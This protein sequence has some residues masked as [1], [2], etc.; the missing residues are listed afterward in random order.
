MDPATENLP[1]ATE[2]QFVRKAP[3]PPSALERATV[4][5]LNR[6]YQASGQ[7]KKAVKTRASAARNALRRLDERLNGFHVEEPLFERARAARDQLSTLYSCILIT[8]AVVLGI[9]LFAAVTVFLLYAQ[10]LLVVQC[11]SIY[12]RTCNDRGTCYNGVC[13]CDPLFSGGLCTE[14]QIPGYDLSQ[15]TECN[16]NGFVLPFIDYPEVCLSS[17]TAQACVD[18]VQ[19][20][21][22]LLYPS[23]PVANPLSVPG[24]NTIPICTCFV[25]YGAKDCSGTTCPIDENGYICS[26]H[27]NTSVSLLINATNTGNGCQCNSVYTFY[28][29]NVANMF[30]P[31]QMNELIM[32]YN[33]F[34]NMRYCGRVYLASLTNATIAW[35]ARSDYMCHCADD[36]MGPTCGE[37]KCPQNEDNDAICYGNG[38]PLYGYGR[39][40]NYTSATKGGKDCALQCEEDGF[41]LCSL[42]KCTKSIEA[43]NK[44]PLFKDDIVCQQPSVCPRQQPIRCADGSCVSIPGRQTNQCLLGYAFGSTDLQ[45]VDAVLD[46]YR[47]PNITGPV[48]FTVCFGNTSEVPGVKGYL[49]RGG[50]IYDPQDPLVLYSASPL[51]YAEFVTNASYLAVVPQYRGA[52]PPMHSTNETGY[53]SMVFSYGGETVWG[54][55][56]SDPTIRLT[57]L[58]AVDGGDEPLYYLAPMPWNYS[59]SSD[60]NVSFSTVRLTPFLAGEQK[61]IFT[62]VGSDVALLTM[63]KEGF[64]SNGI[65]VNGFSFNASFTEY[66]LGHR[67]ASN[68]FLYPTNGAIVQKDACFQ[69]LPACSWYFDQVNDQLVNLARTLYI[70][71]QEEGAEMYPVVLAG[72]PCPVAF[73]VFST[74]LWGY[75]HGWHTRLIATHPDILAP[76]VFEYYEILAKYEDTNPD[77]F[78]VNFEFLSLPADVYVYVSAVALLTLRDGILWPCA[79][80]QSLTESNRSAL[81]A[82]YFDGGIVRNLNYLNSVIGKYAVGL[83]QTPV[84]A[85]FSYFRGQIAAYNAQN[86]TVTLVNEQTGETAHVFETAVRHIA[87]TDIVAGQDDCNLEI[88]SFRCPDGSCTRAES[89]AY[90]YNSTC[91]C[92]YA[93]PIANCSCIDESLAQWGCNCNMTGQICL[94]GQPVLKDYEDSLL[95]ELN[96]LLGASCSCIFF[97]PTTELELEP[98]IHAFPDAPEYE[99][100]YGYDQMVDYIRIDVASLL[101]LD[102]RLFA[103]SY[104]FPEIETE[105]PYEVSADPLTPLTRYLIPHLAPDVAYNTIR[106]VTDPVTIEEVFVVFAK[107]GF[108]LGAMDPNITYGASSN[109]Q[110]AYKVSTP[111]DTYWYPSLDARYYP[112]YIEMQYTREYY[113][114]FC[115]VSFVSTGTVISGSLTVL[116]VRVYL[117]AFVTVDD[118]GNNVSDWVTLGS[119]SVFANETTGP[120]QKTLVFSNITET[121]YSKFRL[122]SFGALFGVRY[123]NLYTKQKCECESISTLSGAP[124]VPVVNV[125][126]YAGLPT[127]QSQLDAIA[128][129]EDGLNLSEDCICVDNCTVQGAN[130]TDNGVCND[131][132]ALSHLTGAQSGTVVNG[133]TGSFSAESLYQ[134]ILVEN[135][136]MDPLFSSGDQGSILFVQFAND[137]QFLNLS[138]P[139]S[140]LETLYKLALLGNTEFYVNENVTVFFFFANQSDDYFLIFNQT[141]SR[142]LFPLAYWVPGTMNFTQIAREMN[143]DQY[144]QQGLAC[145]AGLD[146]LD[147]GPSSRKAAEFPDNACSLKPE[148]QALR[149][150]IDQ[151]NILVN[152]SYAVLDLFALDNG[153]G[154]DFNGIVVQ[155]RVRHTRYTQCI[156]QVCPTLALPFMCPS[157]KCVRYESECDSRYTCPGNGCVQLPALPGGPASYRCACAPGYGGNAC[158]YGETRGAT[159]FIGP[160]ERGAVPVSQTRACGALPPFRLK[161][162]I[163][164]SGDSL[165]DLTAEKINLLNKQNRL[166][167]GPQNSRDYG[168]HCV[169]PLHAPFGQPLIFKT[170]LKDATLAYSSEKERTIWQSCAC[171]RKGFYGEQ[172]LMSDDIASRNPY[173]GA[174]TWKQWTHPKTKAVQTFEWKDGNICAYNDFPFRCNNGQCVEEPNMCE[175]SVLMYPSCNGRGTCLADGSCECESIYRTFSINE[176]VSEYIRYPYYYSQI[177]HTTNP[178]IWQ[179]NFNWRHFPQSQCAARNCLQQNGCPIPRGCFPGTPSLSFR[180][181]HFICGA[182][183]PFPGR[184]APTVWLCYNGK[185]LTMPLPCFGN[186]ILRYKDITNEPYCICGTPISPLVNISSVTQETELRPNGWGGPDCSRYWANTAVPLTWSPW[187]F[188]LNLPHKSKITGEELPGKWIKGNIVV[189]PKPEDRAFWDSC[190]SQWD[191]LEKCEY[192]PCRLPPDI[193][194]MLPEACLA[195]GG[196]TAPLVYNCNGHGKPRADG[197]CECEEEYTYDTSQ[198]SE[199]GCYRR[200]Q[201]P[202]SKI[203]GKKCN[204]VDQCTDPGQWR[205]PFPL[206]KYYE[207]QW[208]TCGV[209]GMGEYSNTTMLNEVSVNLY[210]FQSQLIQSLSAVAISVLD[211]IASLAGCVCVKPEDSDGDYCCMEPA[212]GET[213][214]YRQNYK[215]PYLLNVTC[216]NATVNAV[217]VLRPTLIQGGK[218]GE[219]YV[220]VVPG[221]TLQFNLEN[222][223]S[224]TVSAVRLYGYVPS[225]SDMQAEFKTSDGRYYCSVQGNTADPVPIQDGISEYN[226]ILPSVGS[227]LQCGPY[228]QCATF[229]SLVSS[230]GPC[231]VAPESRECRALKKSACVN[232]GPEYT[233]WPTGSVN[234]YQGCNRTAD[235]FFGGCT[236]CKLLTAEQLVEDGV[237]LIEFSSA[238]APA[239]SSL[240]LGNVEFYGYTD[241]AL[242]VPY[243]LKRTLDLR[244]SDVAT[245]CQDDRFL[246][247][248]LGA[249]KSYFYDAANQSDAFTA[250]A[251]CRNAGGYLAALYDAN[252]ANGIS[253]LKQTCNAMRTQ[254]RP[255]LIGAYDTALNRT[256]TSRNT[257]FESCSTCRIYNA[258]DNIHVMAAQSDTAYTT[259]TQSYQV[260]TSEI[261]DYYFFMDECFSDLLFQDN[262][263]G[264][265]NDG[266]EGIRPP[267]MLVGEVGKISDLS[268]SGYTYPAATVRACVSGCGCIQFRT[269]PFVRQAR[270]GIPGAG[271]EFIGDSDDIYWIMVGADIELA[272][273]YIRCSPSS[274]DNGISRYANFDSFTVNPPILDISVRNGGRGSQNNM[275]NFM[276]GGRG[277]VNCFLKGHGD[278]VCDSWYVRYCTLKGPSASGGTLSF[279]SDNTDCLKAKDGRTGT[280]NSFTT[281]ARTEAGEPLFVT[282]V[283]YKLSTDPVNRGS[284]SFGNANIGYANRQYMPLFIK[285]QIVSIIMR[286]YTDLFKVW[287]K[288]GPFWYIQP[289]QVF[290]NGFGYVSR[291]VTGDPSY[292]AQAYA[293]GR[294]KSLAGLRQYLKP[295]SGTIAECKDCIKTLSG[296]NQW[297]QRVYSPTLL[298]PGTLSVAG[299]KTIYLYLNAANTARGIIPTPIR[300][301]ESTNPRMF[302]YQVLFLAPYQDNPAPAIDWD[303][304]TCWAVGA[305]GLVPALCSTDIYPYICQYDWTKYTV[306][307]G[308][309]CD[310]C[311]PSTRIGGE[312]R[313]NVTCYDDNKLANATAYPFQHAVK[314]AYLAN[315]LELFA[316]IYNM[317]EQTV[318]FANSSVIW[319]F[320]NAWLAWKTGYSSRL[321]QL[322]L[323]TRP[324]FS[325]WCD[326]SLTQN[327]PINC[328]RNI[329]PH[330]N[331]VERYCAVETAYCNPDVA[332]P[333]S[334]LMQQKDV[335]TIYAPVAEEFSYTT[336]SCGETYDL[337]MYIEPDKFGGPQR[338]FLQNVS[339]VSHVPNSYIELLLQDTNGFNFWYNTGKTNVRYTLQWNI[340][341]SVFVE[342]SLY[343][344]TGCVDP[345]IEVFMH[346]LSPQYPDIAETTR[347]SE[348]FPLQVTGGDT[349]AN[350]IANFTV[351]ST[352]TG[353]FVFDGLTFP[354]LVF[355]GFGFRVY[356][357]T[358]NTMLKVF[359]PLIT[360]NSTRA[361]CTTRESPAYYSTKYRIQS[362]APD[363]I[364]LHTEADL[365]LFPGKD[366]GECG[367]D[368]A[369]AGEACDCPAVTSFKYKERVCGGFGREGKLALAPDGTTQLTGVGE[370]AGCYSYGAAVD[371]DTQDVGRLLYTLLVPGAT[372]DYPSVYINALPVRGIS[373]FL[374]IPDEGKGVHAHTY[375][376]TETMCQA[377]GMIVPVYYSV[378]ELTQ[379]IAESRYLYPVFMSVKTST[380]TENS[381]PWNE[382][383]DGMY[384]VNETADNELWFDTYE[385]GVNPNQCATVGFADACDL[386]N[387]NN[388]A[389]GGTITG[390]SL[391]IN[392][393]AYTGIG[394]SSSGT[395]TW[396]VESSE[397][398]YVYV[399]GTGTITTLTCNGGGF[400]ETSVGTNPRRYECRCPARSLSFNVPGTITEIQVFNAYDTTRT[401][402]Y[403][404]GGV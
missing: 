193:K 146:C 344:C 249:D 383:I 385:G 260:S 204:A 166:G 14:T 60:Y 374:I 366:L 38:H 240:N 74:S 152:R 45:Q 168:Y 333:D 360:D 331:L 77:T 378:D 160:D 178:T 328:G 219:T 201:C 377:N 163:T 296:I 84:A 101:A 268:T 215:S 68:N 332:V 131:A 373:I 266:F 284:A 310:A 192:V 214:T 54:T 109:Y 234:V 229:A 379:L 237:L 11:P 337:Y 355:K 326:M 365:Q 175:Q 88:Q 116:P 394:S 64:A 401:T 81:N 194:C 312:P 8:L 398:I 35:G 311:G 158:Q 98:D 129:W 29:Q 376:E 338:N 51:I 334:G 36:Y 147:C 297:R 189:G 127:I 55:P 255:C 135:V 283:G 132:V 176:E 119:W 123:W 388:Y 370:N 164:L 99:F 149:L 157:G 303:V 317:D 4:P 375:T 264:P 167:C 361:R 172:L 340:T 396:T 319:G 24:S 295:W 78:N 279:N 150:L 94:C 182:E 206:E 40:T 10:K 115:D 106:I 210:N 142:F 368:F 183:T 358:P 96:T 336:R 252:E 313:A 220:R 304:P 113:V 282:Y 363:N 136:T 257:M 39:V 245:S 3:P 159:P 280:W 254:G 253:L 382:G 104:L 181:K 203:T 112:V 212:S 231:S 352:F 191:R 15:N 286:E 271:T 371:C 238:A 380:A 22:S 151:Q 236:C 31:E 114:D 198:F 6:F 73:T 285:A 222:N 171:A 281:S 124:L 364:C 342:Y 261:K 120:V 111:D 102:P 161:P 72:E 265:A 402:A 90:T 58:S 273:T 315:S 48:T 372:F 239:T 354:S 42:N 288:Y 274:R 318:D 130:V 294:Y 122:I 80:P 351:N 174:I 205:H 322:S 7:L 50:F 143:Y 202:V 225:G 43:T 19:G 353:S 208:F 301:L 293:V 61:W 83:I 392:G 126:S 327:F 367:C 2:V 309:Q 87:R 140:D 276:K 343:S 357:V 262:Y 33:Y 263:D 56:K 316:V 91:N 125:T 258:A 103:S 5:F 277:Q 144:V 348:H 341:A 400:C 44:Y 275:P 196:E 350:F 248:K 57:L 92:T 89:S 404:Y 199:K 221:Q 218:I 330:T 118:A 26:L 335:P 195:T 187:N 243:S 145:A 186:G 105:V 63:D 305:N 389:Y 395:L 141:V 85:Q 139:E 403:T 13:V 97:M 82:G 216:T 228:Y 211:A 27:G 79:C 37:G 65:L 391:L 169:M 227:A 117:E 165:L 291:Q 308:Y 1:V 278:Q 46:R 76:M 346:T 397:H 134:D 23:G 384:F 86:A 324:S 320:K 17:W 190:C 242:P 21:Q 290:F 110:D 108:S 314:D 180:D 153:W 359:F 28:Q 323:N 307:T 289:G 95:G 217:T 67:Q 25:G 162:P 251:K 223:V 224:T 156:G 390:S 100:Q 197:S 70:C 49:P 62:A 393:D 299:T 339:L 325:S 52:I 232:A 41:E 381:W 47:C 9:V 209:Q 387:F 188:E 53:Q 133:S 345:S 107:E 241:T 137:E 177:D 12:G 30:T 256:Y 16:G 306:V 259:A 121:T 300:T 200:V 292:M 71:Y 226:W 247:S 20:I 34:Y 347:I 69:D 321:G 302:A 18:Y 349:R 75:F 128:L 386:F 155:R 329:N 369:F 213:Y 184:C 66:E 270:A 207:Q 399:F 230:E 93:S 59:S 235:S 138:A 356:G 246:T 298:W 287:A 179:L 267:C 244:N 154:I 148:L 272:G 233:Y 185:N 173:T 170:R 250:D 269:T 362:R 32:H